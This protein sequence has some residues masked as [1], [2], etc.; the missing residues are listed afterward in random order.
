MHSKKQETMGN[1]FRTG[2]TLSAKV[3][4]RYKRTDLGLLPNDWN[5]VRLGDL[6]H[7]RMV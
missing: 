3:P 4:V 6:L 1:A 5:A 7:S 2:R